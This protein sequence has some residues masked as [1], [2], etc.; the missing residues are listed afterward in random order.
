MYLFTRDHFSKMHLWRASQLRH[1]TKM[2]LKACCTLEF[3]KHLF[4]QLRNKLHVSFVSFTCLHIVL[5]RFSSHHC[6]Y[7]SEE[8]W[9]YSFL[10]SWCSQVNLGYLLFEQTDLKQDQNLRWCDTAPINVQNGE[11]TRWWLKCHKCTVLWA[12]LG[13]AHF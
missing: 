13:S 7:Y 1:Y 5:V 4:L 10:V 2:S 8:H 11:W 6:L 12:G 9:I 3:D